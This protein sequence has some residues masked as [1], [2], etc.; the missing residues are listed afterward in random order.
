MRHCCSAARFG[1]RKEVLRVFR[2]SVANVRVSARL[3]MDGLD[4]ARDY[5]LEPL[6]AV[7]SAD[8]SHLLTGGGDKVVVWHEA[9]TGKSIRRSGR[10]DDPVGV[11]AISP[12][13]KMVSTGLMHA[14]N[15]LMPAP[16]LVSEADSGKPITQ[17]MPPSLPLGG[18]WMSDGRL[19][20]VTGDE[21]SIR[22][23]RVR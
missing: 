4:C 18:G 14:A 12:D 9:T 2:A 15:L 8:G 5:T 23:W 11:L 10:M 7:F 17:W 16:V 20:I 21:T 19:L 6:S 13:G 3:E 1:F 22:L